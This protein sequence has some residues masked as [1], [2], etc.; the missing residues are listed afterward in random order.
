VVRGWDEWRGPEGRI[1]GVSVMKAPGASERGYKKVLAIATKSTRE[2]KGS[3]GFTWVDGA[4]RNVEGAALQV[5]FARC[6]VIALF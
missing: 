3:K 1:A 2:M 4:H 5:E 6:V